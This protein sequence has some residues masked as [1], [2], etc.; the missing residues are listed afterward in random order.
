MPKGLNYDEEIEKAFRTW[1]HTNGLNK[2]QAAN[3]YEG[4]VK[5]QFDKH[6][7]WYTDQTQAKSKVEQDLRREH[8]AQYEQFLTQAKTAVGRYT[9]PDFQK[10]LD[11][12]GMGNDPRMIRAFG[13][14]GKEMN[15]DTRLK[16]QPQQTIAVDDLDKAI[17]DFRSTHQKALFDRDNPDHNRRVAEMQKLFTARFGD[18]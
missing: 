14:I 2:K 1:A 17:S 18:Q 11:E 8:G 13:R 15:G 12:T 4:Y 16:G 5:T 6:S 9:D 7:A 3:L 10:W